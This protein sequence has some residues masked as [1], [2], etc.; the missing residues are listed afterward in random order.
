MKRIFF[1]LMATILA[2]LLSLNI[3][4]AQLQVGV[5]YRNRFE[6]RDGYQKLAQQGSTPA[7]L[8]SQRTR[9]SLAWKS[10]NLKLKFTPQDIRLWGDEDVESSTG[11]FG[12]YASLE[13]FEGYAEMR[14]S[15]PLWISVGRQQLVYDNKRLL[16]DR[17]WNQSGMAYDA[18]VVKYTYNELTVHIGSVWNTLKELNSENTYPSSRI[19]SLNYVWLNQQLGSLAKASFMHVSSGIT[20]S[21]TTNHLNFR[22]TTGL[23]GEFK[24]EK[25]SLL[26]NAYYQFG[27]NVFGHSVSAYLIDID[28]SINLD[29]LKIG[30]GL[31]YLSGNSHVGSQQKTDHLFDVLYGN[32][33]K[34]FG[35]QDYFRSFPSNTKEGGLQDYFVYIEGK[36]TPSVSV[37]NTGHFFSL[38][39]INSKTPQEKYLGFENDLLVSYAFNSWGKLEVGYSF[40]L[41][42]ESLKLLQ[43][44]P[45]EKFSQFLYCQLAI[46]TDIFNQ[47]NQ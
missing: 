25:F 36:I 6:L 46:S 27:K 41:P 45:N 22:Q 26:G 8:V 40:V 18:V 7:F 15:H 37:L 9:I 14:I 29:P 44:V 20:E 16:G 23:F 2:S 39:E 13:M 5:Q 4:H 24:S 43:G 35:L 11:V 28:A 10:E 1:V 30:A 47:K 19:K 42:T 33:H 12:S 32:R 34:F 17:N 21:D 38:A 31:S 3:L